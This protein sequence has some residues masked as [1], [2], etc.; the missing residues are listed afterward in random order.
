MRATNMV[1]SFKLIMATL[2]RWCLMSKGIYPLTLT[3]FDV[4]DVRSLTF[5][6]FSFLYS[7]R[8]TGLDCVNLGLVFPTA[9][10]LCCAAL[11]RRTVIHPFSTEVCNCSGVMV[12]VTHTHSV[13]D[14]KSVV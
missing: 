2:N 6:I 13:L 14:R 5:P 1:T 8:S 4:Q 11:C 3:G 7:F 12:T 9:L 10:Y